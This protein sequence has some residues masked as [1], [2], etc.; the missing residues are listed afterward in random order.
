M[1]K[2]KA[3]RD[4]EYFKSK[5]IINDDVDLFSRKVLHVHS[6]DY[7]IRSH[8]RWDA[9]ESNNNED[10]FR[11]ILY[12]YVGDFQD[13]VGQGIMFGLSSKYS[14][15]SDFIHTAS[16]R[17]VYRKDNF[18]EAHIVVGNPVAE[19]NRDIRNVITASLKR[20]EVA[21]PIVLPNLTKGHKALSRITP[22]VGM[23]AYVELADEDKATLVFYDGDDWRIVELGR[24]VNP[25]KELWNRK[26]EVK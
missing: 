9:I 19:N 22:E 12:D 20:I 15:H 21:S 18:H 8:M 10:L 25:Y 16:Y 7:P 14:N 11:G 5:V 26:K 6:I 23:L 17:G 3:T 4:L 13:K 1:Q 2:S 24:K